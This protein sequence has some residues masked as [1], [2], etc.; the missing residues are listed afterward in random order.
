[1][2]LPLNL[3][4]AAAA[5]GVA[6]AFGVKKVVDAYSDNEEAKKL[7]DGSI[8]VQEGEGKDVDGP[9]AIEDLPDETKLAYIEAIIWLVYH[10]DGCIDG[11]EFGELR[12]L[13]TQLNFSGVLRRRTLA[14][15]DDAHDLVLDGILDRLN[16]KAPKGVERH[17][18]ISLVK[19]MVRVFES[20]NGDKAAESPQIAEACGLL[21]ID[22]QQLQVINDGVELDRQVFNGSVSHGELKKIAESLASK[23]AGVGVPI[24]AIYLSGSVVGLS[25]PGITSGLAALGFGGLLG[26]SSMVTGIGFVVLLA[27]IAYRVTRWATSGDDEKKRAQLRELML[28]EV[29][30]THQKAMVGLGEDLAYFAQK[31]VDLSKNVLENK[32]KIERLGKEVTLFAEAL[33]QLKR[34][35]EK[36]ERALRAGDPAQGSTSEGT[37]MLAPPEG[38]HT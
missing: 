36:Y 24:A 31:I 20:A 19:D 5:A 15:M 25:A 26:L 16:D 13:M 21:D 23:A 34:R 9:I 30:R 6:G 2:P 27:G 35:G 18:A 12:L 29:L 3:I 10:D 4:G 17:I 14:M 7:G 38:D 37:R 8:D 33:A 11:R 22:E 32:L 28:Q 1:M